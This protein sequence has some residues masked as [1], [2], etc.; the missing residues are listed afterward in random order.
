MT[1]A[2]TN[3]AER[4]RRR[5]TFAD[6]IFDEANW[7]LS[8][9]G[10]RAQVESKPLELLRQLLL[11][12]GSLVSKDELLSAIWRDV[13]VV[14][15]SL[16]TAVR[17]LRLA[18]DDDRRDQ[19]IIETV[20]RLGYRL[21]ASVEVE[22]LAPAGPAAANDARPQA[23]PHETDAGGRRRGYGRLIAAAGG[24]A[25]AIAIGGLA[26][27]SAENAGAT[28]SAVSYGNR[29]VESALRRLDVG[30]IER[31]LAAGWNPNSLLDTQDNDAIMHLLNMCEW[32]REHDQG[33]MLL[34]V[35]TLLDAGAR[36]D[37]RNVWGDTAYSIA[38]A[39]RYCGPNHPVTRS[40]RTACYA[41]YRP[42]ADRCLASYEIARRE[43][44]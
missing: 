43:G 7:T 1:D 5:W 42:L 31:M 27:S 2:R 21:T 25:A 23:T 36:L 6:C 13:V 37:H 15:A 30:A 10:R 41:G 14:E 20:Q 17:K 12:P 8:V 26:L 19:P 32:N 39:Q 11:S 16:P 24:L 35:R 22:E 18:L 34:M 44:R 28:G 33:Q 38:K 9:G 4:L 40:I 29:E 3:G